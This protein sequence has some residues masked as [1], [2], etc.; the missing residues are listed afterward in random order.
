MH[1]CSGSPS[2]RG[3]LVDDSER[4][5]KTP[6]ARPTVI[7]ST[8]LGAPDVTLHGCSI[9]CGSGGSLLGEAIRDRRDELGAFQA[10][11][12][13]EGGVHRKYVGGIERAECRPAAATAATLGDYAR[14]RLSDLFA[15]PRRE[16]C[17]TAVT[18]VSSALVALSQ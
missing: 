7:G 14:F 5:F 6:P 15:K 4:Q 17:I 18:A 2:T 3:L 10:R 12:G 16:L 8:S 11:L 1:R 9:R 13:L